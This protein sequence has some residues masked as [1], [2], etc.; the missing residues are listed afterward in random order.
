MALDKHERYTLNDKQR[1]I[2]LARIKAAEDKAAERD[3]N[4]DDDSGSY[5]NEGA[6]NLALLGGNYWVVMNRT[7]IRSVN[8]MAPVAISKFALITNGTREFLAKPTKPRYVDLADTGKGLLNH[9]WRSLSFDEECDMCVWDALALKF[10][11]V[12]IGWR[13]E[14]ERHEEV[15]GA[16]PDGE[17]PEDAQSVMAP[18]GEMIEPEAR[19]YASEDE[20]QA[21]LEA[22]NETSYEKFVVDEPFIERFDPRDLLVDPKCKRPD[23]ADA[24]YVFRRKDSR[25]DDLKRNKLYRNTKELKATKQGY[26]GQP[27]KNTQLPASV[28]DSVRD[29]FDETVVYDGYVWLSLKNSAS[30]QFVHIVWAKGMDKELLCEPFRYEW[31][32]KNPYPFEICCNWRPS[33]D[34]LQFASDVSQ[35]RS[36]QIEHDESY[37]QVSTMRRRGVSKWFGP[38]LEEGNPII[39]HLESG[40]EGDY[41]GMPEDILGRV[42]PSERPPQNFEAFQFLETVPNT[43]RELWGISQFQLNS[44]PDKEVKAAEVN[45]MGS[46]GGTR[47]ELD[48]ESYNKFVCRC[49]YKVL[50]LLQ[51]YSA[52][53]RPYLFTTE[54][55]EEQWGTA[56]LETLRGNDPQNPSSLEPVGVQFAIELTADSV[57]NRNRYT[58]RKELSEMMD[59]LAA[60][61]DLPHPERPGEPLINAPAV[62]REYVK[63]YDLGNM[64]EIIK[65]PMSEPDRIAL[66]EQLADQAAQEIQRLRSQVSQLQQSQAPV[67]GPMAG[68]IMPGGMG[69]AP[70][71]V[72]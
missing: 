64:T 54:A 36:L 65:P 16:R 35:T 62:V 15:R 20:A 46:Q 21:A 4:R 56:T 67:A 51:Q 43:M 26:S 18:N 9:T 7:D 17:I 45:Y 48:R 42:R 68:A 49:A 50:A 41:V 12:E 22:A 2:V 28:S 69:G 58:E 63:S 23:F 47:Q 60:Y 72:Q 11:V 3:K 14:T 39:E 44:M 61:K 71:P 25:I 59:K 1:A 55:G 40:D 24:R 31:R 57:G 52:Q 29:D 53:S 8:H 5:P 13:V 30:P 70:M 19:E 10:G 6:R 66:L 27:D 37:T 32:A 34:D 38:E 33:N